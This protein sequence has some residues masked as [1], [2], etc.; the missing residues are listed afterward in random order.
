MHT[1]CLC[2]CVF[3]CVCVCV[4]VSATTGR[5][6]VWVVCDPRPCVSFVFLCA[7]GT[8]EAT[9]HRRA[10]LVQCEHM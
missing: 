5:G 1:V 8:C 10:Q 7:R 4:C 6:V 2:V 9:E 3:V